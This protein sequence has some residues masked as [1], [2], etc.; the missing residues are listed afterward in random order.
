MNIDLSDDENT[1][2]TTHDVYERL[3]YGKRANVVRPA[4]TNETSFVEKPDSEELR[5]QGCTSG[6]LVTPRSAM[7]I[8]QTKSRYQKFIRIKLKHSN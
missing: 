3:A 2:K 6:K 7:D 5:K 8:P 1:K 4:H